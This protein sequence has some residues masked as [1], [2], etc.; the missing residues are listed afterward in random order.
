MIS[1]MEYSS[2]SGCSSCV[3]PYQHHMKTL[4]ACVVMVSDSNSGRQVVWA[5]GAGGAA[6]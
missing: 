5:T 2:V 4:L 3:L 1:R 6:S